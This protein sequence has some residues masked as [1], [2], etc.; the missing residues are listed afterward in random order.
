MPA[1]SASGR[2]SPGFEDLIS[3]KAA[4]KKSGLSHDHLRRLAGQ[5]EFWAK[6]IGRDWVTTEKA[7]REYL[8]RGRRPGPS[9][10]NNK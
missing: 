10:R 5:G 2:S 4:A 7:V 1:S 3:L 9:G 8:A 6:K